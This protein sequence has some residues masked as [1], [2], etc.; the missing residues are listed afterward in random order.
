TQTVGVIGLGR[1]GRNFAIKAHALEYNIIGYDPYYKENE[2]TKFI[3]IKSLEDVIKESDI[4]SLHIPADGNKNLFNDETFK[5]MKNNAIIIN[6]ARGGIINED[7]LYD[8]LVNKEIAGAAIDCAA[9]EPMMPNNKL[10]TLDNYLATPH[11]AWYSEEAALELKRKVAEEC[12]SFLKEHTVRYP[13][14][15]LK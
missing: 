1:I 15:H 13:I 5:M 10:F 4:I 12:V 6:V 11:M 9:T 7:D 8:A 14:N 3:K 2:N